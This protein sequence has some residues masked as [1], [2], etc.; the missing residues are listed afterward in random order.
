MEEAEKFVLMEMPDNENDM[1]GLCVAK[2][3]ETMAEILRFF[4][5]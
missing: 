2:T 4:N 1:T 5:G 3:S